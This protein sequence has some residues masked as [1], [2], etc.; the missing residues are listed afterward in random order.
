M[1]E[2]GENEREGKTVAKMTL[3]SIQSAPVHP[4]RTILAIVTVGRATCAAPILD[5]CRLLHTRGHQVE[6]ACLEGWQ[7]LA[8]PH[9]FISRTH[10]VGRDL[11]PEEDENLYR[12]LDASGIGT[13]DARVKMFQ[14]FDIL[15]SWW[16]ETYGNIKRLCQDTRPDFLFVDELADSAMDVAREL[17]IPFAGMAPQAP[18]WG[19]DCSYVSGMP[20]Y[21]YAET[22]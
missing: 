18:P 13:H 20:G 4:S 6:F 16:A 3:V 22:T 1:V 14:G 11:T 10:T 15:F 21:Q 9:E 2:G 19:I 12:V 17:N 8:V 7:K 5:I